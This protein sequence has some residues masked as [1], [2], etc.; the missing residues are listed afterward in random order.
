MKITYPPLPLAGEGTGEGGRLGFTPH[1]NPLPLS[2]AR[3]V[4]WVYFLTILKKWISAFGIGPFP[5]INATVNDSGLQNLHE[6]FMPDPVSWMPHTLGWYVVFGL[7]LLVAGWWVYGRLRR[8]RKNR[9]RRL[10]LAELAVI[11]EELQQPERRAKTLAEIP[12]LL[13][14][15]ALSA[16]PRS[17]VAS[18]TGEKW[19]AFL[20]KTMG[21]KDFTEGEGQLLPD[22]AYAPVQRAAQLTD[23]QID[24]I[25]HLIRRWIKGH[26]AFHT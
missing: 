7:I 20:D 15:T 17:D 21:G 23:E 10:A 3:R 16:F 25:F 19:L 24:N 8:F 18:L 22:L 13:K 4:F 14:R 12:T 11:Q 5:V 1:L 26:V 9:Y 6:I 2:G